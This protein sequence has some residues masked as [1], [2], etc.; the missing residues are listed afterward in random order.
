[1]NSTFKGLPKGTF[2]T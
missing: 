2:M 1:V